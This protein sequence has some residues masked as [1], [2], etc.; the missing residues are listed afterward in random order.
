MTKKTPGGRQNFLWGGKKKEES[1]KNGR[2]QRLKRHRRTY[3]KSRPGRGQDKK[4]VFQQQRGGG[5][6]KNGDVGGDFLK[7]RIINNG[8]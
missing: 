6:Q 8:N 3:A 1:E 4:G 7:K 2:L 5:T